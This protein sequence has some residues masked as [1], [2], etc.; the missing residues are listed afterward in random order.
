MKREGI[1][2]SKERNVIRKRE[3]LGRTRR[4]VFPTVCFSI[5][6]IG[7]FYTLIS[8]HSTFVAVQRKMGKEILKFL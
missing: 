8:H 6:P 3:I 7:L 4:S 1:G 5:V 2:Q